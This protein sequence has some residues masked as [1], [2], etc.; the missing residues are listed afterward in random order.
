MAE[1]RK[2]EKWQSEWIRD[3]EYC[4]ENFPCGFMMADSEN[5][6]K[7]LAA[8]M[9]YV[10]G[11]SRH[12]HPC[13]FREK[14][15]LMNYF[16]VPEESYDYKQNIWIV[17]IDCDSHRKSMKFNERKDGTVC[18]SRLK[19]IRSRILEKMVSTPTLITTPSPQTKKRKSNETDSIEFD[20]FVK[21]LDVENQ[22][23]Y[24]G[25]FCDGC[26]SSKAHLDSF[27]NGKSFL[28]KDV[29]VEREGNLDDYSDEKSYFI[30]THKEQHFKHRKTWVPNVH[31]IVIYY[32]KRET[33][34]HQ[35][36]AKLK[37]ENRLYYAYSSDLE[38]FTLLEKVVKL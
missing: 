4:V 1:Q 10:D 31:S 33:R 19:Q 16:E 35:L 18:P 13:T 29:V 8:H 25:M 7:L 14:E 9:E 6:A 30:I 20:L 32:M 12:V 34:L 26:T 24:G 36:I 27:F 3:I 15:F 28:L 2:M 23:C 5:Y 21:E 22:I 37:E 17:K 38:K 11:F